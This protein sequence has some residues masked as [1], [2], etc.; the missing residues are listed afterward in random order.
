MLP[1]ASSEICFRK[2]LFIA[3]CRSLQAAAA[4]ARRSSLTLHLD[5]PLVSSSLPALSTAHRSSSPFFGPYQPACVACTSTGS[6]VGH[7]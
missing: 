1:A 7:K 4:A 3:A 6:I 5:L 2:K